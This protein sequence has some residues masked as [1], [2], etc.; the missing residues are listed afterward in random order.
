MAEHAKVVKR[1]D[2]FLVLQGGQRARNSSGVAHAPL[3]SEAA[4]N[5]LRDRINAAKPAPKKATGPARGL[6]QTLG[7]AIRRL[8]R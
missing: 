1:G 8:A 2:K 6:G 3:S 7:R 5:G 4:A